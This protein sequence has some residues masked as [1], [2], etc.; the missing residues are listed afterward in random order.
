MPG[1]CRR[2]RNAPTH[3]YGEENPIPSPGF[4]AKAKLLQE[5]DGWVRH[6]DRVCGK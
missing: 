4:E 2:R 5:I 3:L 6:K 1:R